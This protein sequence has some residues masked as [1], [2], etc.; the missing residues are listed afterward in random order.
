MPTQVLPQ[1]LESEFVI[2]LLHEIP[3]I[4]VALLLQEKEKV[5]KEILVALDNSNQ[6]L[7]ME[8]LPKKAHDQSVH[9]RSWSCRSRGRLKKAGCYYLRSREFSGTVT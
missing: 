4:R 1:E 3:N 9:A 7:E 2:V 5:S 6:F 8:I